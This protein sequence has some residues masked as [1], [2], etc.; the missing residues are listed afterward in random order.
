VKVRL[1]IVLALIASAS[2]VLYAAVPD[3]RTVTWKR[4][5]RRSASI[6]IRRRSWT[7]RH[8]CSGIC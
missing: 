1:A 2:G 3:P 7:W 8:A 5:L 6:R 4:R